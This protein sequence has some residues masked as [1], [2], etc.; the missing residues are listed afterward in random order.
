MDRRIIDARLD[1]LESALR[2]AQID[3]RPAAGY[4][5]P[6]T[7]LRARY[8]YAGGWTALEERNRW[9]AGETVFLE[10]PLV[11]PGDVRADTAYR[12]FF[13]GTGWEG[14]LSHRER[15]YA[16]LDQNHPRAPMD[17]LFERLHADGGGREALTFAAEFVSL[18]RVWCDPSLARET[19]VLHAVVLEEEDR[20]MREA[21]YRLPLR[22]EGGPDDGRRVPRSRIRDVPRGSAPRVRSHPV[23]RRAC[24]AR[25]RRRTIATGTGFAGISPDPEG[26]KVLLTGHSH[27]DVAWLWPLAETVR[28]CAR[29]F[30][31][32]C[33][34]L[35]QDPLL[36]LLLQPAAALRLYEAPLSLPLRGD[37][38]SCGVRPLGGERSHVGGG[39]LQHHLGR[40]AH[41]SDHERGRIFRVGVRQ[42]ALDLLASRRVRLSGN[43]PAD[44]LRLRNPAVLYEQA[45]LAGDQTAFPAICSG[46]R[47]RTGAGF[48][49]TSHCSMRYYNGS[50]EPEQ[51]LW[52]IREF[53]QKDSYDEVMLPFGHGDGG[54][55][56]TEEMHRLRPKGRIV[57]G[58]SLLP[59]RL[60]RRPTSSGCGRRVAELPVWR[61]ELYLE[62][63]RGTFTSQGRV[64]AANRRCETLLRQAEILR[65]FVG[66]LSAGESSADPEDGFRLRPSGSAGGAASTAASAGGGVSGAG[67]GKIASP[68]V[69]ADSVRAG[70]A[71]PDGHGRPAAAARPSVRPS[72]R[73]SAGLSGAWENTSPSA[74]PRYSSRLLHRSRLRR[75]HWKTTGDSRG[76][77]REYRRSM[78]A[79]IRAGGRPRLLLFNTLSF[80]RS[81]PVRLPISRRDGPIEAVLPDGCAVPLQWVPDGG[82][83][84]NEGPGCY[85]A[86]P[87][88]LISLGA[89]PLTLRTVSVHPSSSL[90]VSERH[91]ENRFFRLEL[92]SRGEITRLFDKSAGREV[93][94]RGKTGNRFQ[95][96]QDGPERESAWNVHDSFALREYLFDGESAVEVSEAG[97]VRAS[98]L[99]HRRHRETTIRQRICLYESIPRI[100]FLTE[101]DWR[102]RQTMLKVAFPVE[103]R[104]EH[105]S[106]EIQY[107]VVER[108]THRNTGWDQAKFEVPVHRWVDL[109]EY[110][111]GVSLANDGKYGCDVVENLIRLTLLRG[112]E[113]P[114]PEADRGVHRFTYSLLPHEGDWRD[115]R[116]VE[117]AWELN[118]P[119]LCLPAATLKGA[120]GGCTAGSRIPRDR[121]CASRCGEACRGRA[122]MDPAVLRALRCPGPGAG[123]KVCRTGYRSCRAPTSR[124][125]SRKGVLTE[126]FRAHRSRVLS[127]SRF[128]PGRSGAF[129]CTGERTGRAP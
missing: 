32:A 19:A 70:S 11:P 45:A 105:A 1:T 82:K 114:D 118:E 36:R 108:P 2:A 76:G 78:R 97:P 81:D 109:S 101:V 26:V 127:S 50:P 15:P 69:G 129:A 55:G 40:V 128:F 13:D 71:D 115:A 48:S 103:V 121:G 83:P 89:T 79:L 90:S 34:L 46:G 73:G 28:K 84:G 116:T 61:G 110:G 20:R 92:D 38:P 94:A 33:R 75:R 98:V 47:E 112:P 9:P 37:H 113:Y 93:I 95:L 57:S 16:G 27:I 106:F 25:S 86:Q 62:T 126:S 3:R 123:W 7:S 56:P 10:L 68:A 122:G 22:L 42:A 64:K 43:A 52:A 80:T 65:V 87:P 100:D 91:L 54:G 17:A 5:S 12:L 4:D 8:R 88:G 60:P 99:L 30:S 35:E 96:F 72:R 74:V 124:R 59:G 29:T 44:P 117:R 63:H 31:T 39:G 58:A 49:R 66:L 21:L 107:G 77:E 41:P 119:V 125:P 53:R 67:P 51:L 120:T 111:Y 23:R 6:S 24:G 18:P 14:L 102:E 85:L 104:A